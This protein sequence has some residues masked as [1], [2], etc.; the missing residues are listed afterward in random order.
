LLEWTNVSFYVPVKK[1]AGWNPQ[2]EETERLLKDENEGCTVKGLPH[3]HVV[4]KKS[5]FYKQILFETTG[6]VKP[7]EM[8]AILGPSGS[9]KTSLLNVISQRLG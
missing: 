8:V 7:K 2:K 3:E 1:P 4:K 6:F 9:G 5:K